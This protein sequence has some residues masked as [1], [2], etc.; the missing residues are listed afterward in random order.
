MYKYIY[1]TKNGRLFREHRLIMEDYLKRKLTSN[2][3][4]HHINGNTKDNRIENLQVLSNSEH[5]KLHNKKGNKYAK[6]K[7]LKCPTCKK[8]FYIAEKFYTWK[9]LN[10]QINFH[11]SKKCIRTNQHTSNYEKIVKKGIMENLT[12]YSI[13]K[14]YYIS[15]RTVYYI[16][17][18]LKTKV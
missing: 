7:L 12:G 1:K 10:G 17:K 16:I 18:R 4:I 8:S 3:V 14:K 13:A 11:C 2:E 15:A 9:K 5:S 6:Q